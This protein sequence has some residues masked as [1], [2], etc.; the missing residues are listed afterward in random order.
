MLAADADGVSTLREVAAS[1]AR[2]LAALSQH[3]LL[4]TKSCCA[5]AATS[6]RSTHR[7]YA[8]SGVGTWRPVRVP[9]RLNSPE[10]LRKI[11]SAITDGLS[12]LTKARLITVSA[13]A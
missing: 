6:G 8:C 4:P 10:R 5:E 3:Q 11:R 1:S 7:L 2:P 12:P 9:Q 13:T